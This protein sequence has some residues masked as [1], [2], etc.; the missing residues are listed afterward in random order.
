[1]AEL[2]TSLL[3][4]PN[5]KGVDILLTSPWPRDV[6]TFANSAVSVLFSGGMVFQLNL[7]KDCLSRCCGSLGYWAMSECLRKLRVKKGQQMFW[8]FREEGPMGRGI[9]EIS[10][11]FICL[12]LKNQSRLAFIW[13][14]TLLWICK[15]M[16]CGKTML[17]ASSQ[18]HPTSKKRY[19]PQSESIKTLPHFH[20]TPTPTPPKKENQNQTPNQPRTPLA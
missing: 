6:G 12:C 8:F 2:K 14:Q 7:T 13:S 15:A 1:M 17:F 18:Y 4:T 9:C 16:Y 20:P 3:S 11:W 10:G 5:F 19:D